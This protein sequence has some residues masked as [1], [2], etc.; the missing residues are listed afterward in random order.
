MADRNIHDSHDPRGIILH[1]L[2]SNN[3][4]FCL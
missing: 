2:D 4:F 1:R 3:Y